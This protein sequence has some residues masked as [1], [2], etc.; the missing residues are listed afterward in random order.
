MVTL[1]DNSSY[2]LTPNLLNHSNHFNRS[3]TRSGMHIG[4]MSGN[5]GYHIVTPEML[6]LLE[7]LARYKYLRTSFI[8]EMLDCGGRG[9]IYQLQRRRRQ[10]YIHQPKEQKRGYNNLWCP[11]IHSITKEG[12]RLLHEHGRDPYKVTR[13]DPHQ[14]DVPARNF[15]HSMMICDVMAS[16]EIGLKGTGAKLIPFGEIMARLDPAS[17]PMRLEFN[18]SFRGEAVRGKLV[19]DGLFGIR[20]PD[21]E[22]SFFALETERTNLVGID[23][24][25]DPEKLKKA[26]HR[27]SGLKKIIAYEDITEKKTYK[28]L[29][30]PN[31]RVLF[32]TPN[33]TKAKNYCEMAKAVCGSNTLFLFHDVPVQEEILKAPPPFPS[34]LTADWQRAGMEPTQLFIP[35]NDYRPEQLPLD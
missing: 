9:I 32:I 1:I 20:Y 6:D 33:K 8:R 29:G 23:A 25:I 34:L 22:A 18:S 7:L 27:T 31:M 13:L 26:V 2:F 5:A 21:G 10:G 3:N 24:L 19:P 11:R 12:L 35:N 16:I 28:Q 30:I 15:A 17:D 4:F 14:G